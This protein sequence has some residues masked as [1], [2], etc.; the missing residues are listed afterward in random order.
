[1]SPNVFESKPKIDWKWAIKGF[2]ALKTILLLGHFS[3]RAAA[4]NT[5]DGHH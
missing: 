2:I 4:E 3:T 5:L 1:M